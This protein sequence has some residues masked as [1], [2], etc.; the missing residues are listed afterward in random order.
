MKETKAK[1]KNQKGSS[2]PSTSF[3]YDSRSSFKKKKTVSCPIRDYYSL[4]NKENKNSLIRDQIELIPDQRAMT[5]I[6]PQIQASPNLLNK[7]T[8]QSIICKD[9]VIN[10]NNNPVQID[11]NIDVNNPLIHTSEKPKPKAPIANF[12]FSK[13]KL[14]QEEMTK[15]N[16]KMSLL[17]KNKTPTQFTTQPIVN[18]NNM[19][20][21]NSKLS[22][23]IHAQ[24]DMNNESDHFDYSKEKQP[25]LT[26]DEKGIYGLRELNDYQKVKILGK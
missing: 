6:T 2:M 21:G 19:S 26:N 8:K 17:K 15:Q 23:F 3:S 5:K 7:K 12:K 13:E 20:I 1:T 22:S 11:I 25:E 16:R 9:K 24:Q 18:Y 4:N 10:A 14:Q